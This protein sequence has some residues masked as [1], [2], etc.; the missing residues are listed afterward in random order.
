MTDEELAEAR[1]TK[2][3]DINFNEPDNYGSEKEVGHFSYYTG[4][5]AGLKA[6]RPKWHNLR[7]NPKDFPKNSDYEKLYLVYWGENNYGVALF[8]DSRWWSFDSG[9]FNV[10]EVIAW[11]EL[12]E[13]IEC[14]I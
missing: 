6:G 3:A 13:F 2:F 7:K 4:F 5:L 12:L 8:N 14:R 11:C 10:E 9:L 1:A